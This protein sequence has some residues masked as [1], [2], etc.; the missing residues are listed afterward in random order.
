[1]EILIPTLLRIKPHALRKIG[2]YL[3]NGGFRQ[4]AV[5]YGEGMKELLGE[6]VSASLESAEIRV[7]H[8]K[9][10]TDNDIQGVFSDLFSVPEKAQVL[11][12]IGGGK[13]IDYCKY[14]AFIRQVP[15]ITVPT[16]ISNDGM[17]SPTASLTSQGARK[18]LRAKI[19]YGVVIDTEVVRQSPKKFTYSGIGDMISKHTAIYDWKIAYH[20]TGTPV[21]DFAVLISNQSVENLV[22][23]GNRNVDDLEFLNLL[24]GS[25]VMSGIAMEVS[26]SSRP[27]SGSEHL[28]SHAYDVLCPQPALHGLQVGVA[29][30]AVSWLQKNRKHEVI[31]SLLDETGFFAHVQQTPLSKKHFLDAVRA[32]PT[33]K[34]DYY[35]VLSRPGEIDRLARF[36]DEDPF[37]NTLV[38]D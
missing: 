1:M 6:K 24:A 23:H 5:Y 22:N 21:N 2:K 27:A 10:V 14:V 12:A 38:R 4:I 7:L 8:E 13:V 35:T 9:T 18:S 33:V 11:V 3:R 15:V 29:T 34:K 17:A 19:P 20:D 25:L 37:F 28:I 30:Y 16:S 31:R 36:V 26:G 32:A